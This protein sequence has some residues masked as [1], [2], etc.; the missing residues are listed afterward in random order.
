[1]QD[2]ASIRRGRMT[3]HKVF[4]YPSTITCTG[5]LFNHVNDLIYNCDILEHRKNEMVKLISETNLRL[6][7]GQ[8]VELYWSENFV[9]PKEK[10]FLHMVS[11]KSVGPYSFVVEV[12]KIFAGNEEDFNY[13]TLLLGKLSTFKLFGNIKR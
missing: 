7:R 8:G 10:D 6:Y 13:F 5:F 2:N 9:C 11:M 3:A 4:G 1:M 12:M